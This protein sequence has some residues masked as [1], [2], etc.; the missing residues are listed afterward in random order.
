MSPV[1]SCRRAALPFL[2]V[3]CAA[4]PVAQAAFVV[5]AF[6][7]APPGTWTTLGGF[8]CSVIPLS[9]L[10]GWIGC[11]YALYAKWSLRD[12]SKA[13]RKQRRHMWSATLIAWVAV[14]TVAAIGGPVGLAGAIAVSL[15]MVTTAA[16][17]LV[18]AAP[19]R[20]GR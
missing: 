3:V 2:A 20:Y 1:A 15:L 4:I 11:A 18:L 14:A 17:L 19:G 10:F 5:L 8:V 6:V 13:T 7:A 12:T 16:V 9:I